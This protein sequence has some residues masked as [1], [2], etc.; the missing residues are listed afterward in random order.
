MWDSIAP[1]AIFY[2]ERLA[3]LIEKLEPEIQVHLQPT[4]IQLHTIK[5]KLIGGVHVT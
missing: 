4:S 3:T 2:P 1:V 5:P